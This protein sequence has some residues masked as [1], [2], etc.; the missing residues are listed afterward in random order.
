MRIKC[1]YNKWIDIPKEIYP[2]STIPN[3]ESDFYIDVGAEYTVYAMTV[4]NGYIW[5]YIS[6]NMF[7]YF[8]RWKPPFFF[9]VIDTR[10]SRYWIYTYK[11]FENYTQAH[12]ILAFPEW[13]NNHPDFYDMLSDKNEEETTIFKSYKELM[14]LEFPD[15]SISKIA[16]IGNSEL[17]ICP[18]CINAWESSDEKNGMVRCPKCKRMM[19]NPRYR[20]LWLHL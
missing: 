15:P 6:D 1:I 20:D 13:A 19:H 12:P 8:P 11:K 10:L 17:L 14:D 16:Q 18:D 7:T 5:Y 4:N 3:R 9:E 2:I